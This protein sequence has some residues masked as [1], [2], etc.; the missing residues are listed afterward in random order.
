[1]TFIHNDDAKCFHVVVQR[2][3]KMVVMGRI[4]FEDLVLIE[5]RHIDEKM[6][7]TSGMFKDEK[8]WATIESG[9]H[10]LEKLSTFSKFWNSQ[11][12]ECKKCNWKIITNNKG[13]GSLKEWSHTKVG[14]SGIVEKNINRRGVEKNIERISFEYSFVGYKVVIA[15]IIFGMCRKE[16]I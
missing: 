4:N 3:Y 5:R 9:L 2:T 11:Q 7:V 6:N 14:G 1:M 15:F 13:K 16:G 12:Y 8:K 10:F